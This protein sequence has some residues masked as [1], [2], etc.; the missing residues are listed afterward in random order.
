MGVQ[1]FVITACTN[2]VDCPVRMCRML[3]QA[4]FLVCTGGGPGAMEA[5]NLGIMFENTRNV[6]LYRCSID[7]P[8]SCLQEGICTKIQMKK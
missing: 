4:G 8:P 3:A 6:Y 7:H 5:A 1:F 2:P